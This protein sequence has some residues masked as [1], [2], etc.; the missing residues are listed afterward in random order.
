MGAAGTSFARRSTIGYWNGSNVPSGLNRPSARVVSNRI[1]QQS[2]SNPN[3]IGL[4]DLVWLWGQFLN[5]TLNLIPSAEPPENFPIEIPLDDPV[6]PPGSQIPFARSAFDLSTGTDPG[7][8][9]QQI[10]SLSSYI[11]A[12]MV[13]GADEGRAAALRT[14]ETFGPVAVLDSKLRTGDGPDGALLPM[15]TAGLNNQIVG[16]IPSYF[17]AGDERVNTG[18]GLMSIHTLFVREH[19]RLASEIAS[20]QSSADQESVYQLARK[21]V[22]ALIQ[23]I[24]YEEFIPAI[25]GSDAINPYSGYNPEVNATVS[26]EFATFG[27]RFGHS[28]L[29]PNLQVVDNDDRTLETVPHDQALLNI[30]VVQR[31]GIGPVLKGFASQIMQEVD[32]S[33]IEAMRSI[34]FPG[35]PPLDLVAVDL[36]RARDHGISG[37]NQCR[38]CFGL[39]PFSTFADITPDPELQSKLA[40][41]YVSVDEVDPLIGGLAEPHASGAAFGPLLRA[42]MIEQFTRLRSGDR[43]FYEN[44]PTFTQAEVETIKTTKL[45][46]IIKRNTTITNIQDHVFFLP[47]NE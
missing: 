38:L 13:Y 14:I 15:N 45:S 22:G 1:C 47:R 28:M 24:T 4:T 31:Y 33:V 35:S 3:A 37:Y 32:V 21:W 12:S 30:S 41:T 42:V 18:F 9:R 27:F 7:N 17:M 29:S 39:E 44:D 23:A 10:D 5:H 6:F 25:L 26:D 34:Q 20:R 8:P 40:C 2:G 19:N 36:Q 11:D 43:F 46:D 16:P